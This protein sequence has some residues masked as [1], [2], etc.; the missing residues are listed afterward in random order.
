MNEVALVTISGNLETKEGLPGLEVGLSV[1]VLG[2]GDI[3]TLDFLEAGFS[4]GF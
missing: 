3:L 4:D 2:T 1:H